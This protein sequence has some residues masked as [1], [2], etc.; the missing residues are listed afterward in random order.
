[1]NA[2]EAFAQGAR[3]GHIEG[4][5]R[6]GQYIIGE[7]IELSYEAAC[8]QGLI[9]SLT[10][11]WAR[12]Y[13]MGYKLAVEGSELPEECRDEPVEAADKLDSKARFIAATVARELG[14]LCDED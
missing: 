10:V 13:R 3:C 11:Q 12:G 1:M 4:R 14:P 5:G 9:G 6:A 7:E 2:N 8:N